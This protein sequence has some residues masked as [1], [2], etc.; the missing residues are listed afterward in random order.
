MDHGAQGLAVLRPEEAL[1]W[2]TDK[3]AKNTCWRGA[4][5]CFPS[6]MESGR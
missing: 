4:G 3:M 1:L 2:L 5:R 6:M